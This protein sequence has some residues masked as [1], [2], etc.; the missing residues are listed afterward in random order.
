M[1]DTTPQYLAHFATCIIL[2]AA[3]W[4]LRKSWVEASNS[5]VIR[6]TVRQFRPRHVLPTLGCVSV[7]L[8]TVG[9]L[10]GA[11]PNH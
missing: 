5:P 3:I 9:F 6:A 1:T 10:L 11:L 8:V 4:G 2:L 7:F